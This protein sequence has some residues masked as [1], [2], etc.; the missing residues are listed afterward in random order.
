MSC[1]Q[2]SL[3]P[4]V[5]ALKCLRPNV[6]AQMSGFVPNWGTCTPSGTFQLFKGYIR[7]PVFFS[8]PLIIIRAKI[9]AALIGRATKQKSEHVFTCPLHPGLPFCAF[10]LIFEFVA[11]KTGLFGRED[12]FLGLHRFWGY[13]SESINCSKVP[14]NRKFRNPVLALE[15][16]LYA[17]QS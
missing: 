4:N 7:L 16:V 14:M 17:T 2:M 9:R 6:C 8:F 12:L 1:A 13:T 3:R 11:E 5:L 15:R 10:V